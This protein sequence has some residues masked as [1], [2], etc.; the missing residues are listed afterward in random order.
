MST[1]NVTNDSLEELVVAVFSSTDHLQI[2]YLIAVNIASRA[3]E[4]VALQR[5]G[6]YVMHVYRPGLFGLISIRTKMSNG[7]GFPVRTGDNFR[8]D[9]IAKDDLG[10]FVSLKVIDDDGED[11]LLH[12][13][14]SWPPIVDSDDSGSEHPVE[15]E[16]ADSD[17]AKTVSPYSTL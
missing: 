2:K 6:R 1:F 17:D 13:C 15:E 11:C 12:S 3:T 16:E 8:V 5:E 4:Q 7:Y 10:N 9:V 14:N